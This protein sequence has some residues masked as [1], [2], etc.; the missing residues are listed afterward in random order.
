[1][2]A[3][4]MFFFLHALWVWS[5]SGLKPEWQMYGQVRVGDSFCDF[6]NVHPAGATSQDKNLTPPPVSRNSQRRRKPPDEDGIISSWWWCW[7]K[8]RCWNK[9][10]RCRLVTWWAA[11][12]RDDRVRVTQH[13][14]PQRTITGDDLSGW[15]RGR[16]Q[17]FG[18]SHDKTRWISTRRLRIL[19]GGMRGLICR[20]Y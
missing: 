2:R 15:F 18:K 16:E 3:L 10:A 17:R 5:R 8:V 12:Y 14:T 7:W 11:D 20:R 19:S 6:C 1:M 4:G 9:T 13:Q